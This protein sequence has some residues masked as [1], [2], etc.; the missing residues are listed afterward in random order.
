MAYTEAN[1][2]YYKKNPTH[3]TADLD[4]DLLLTLIDY[5]VENI[6][7]IKP[8]TAE[9]I[10][11]A[12]KLDPSVFKYIDFSKVSIQ[13]LE[14]VV[15]ENPIMIQHIYSPNSTLIKIA[16]TEDVNVLPYIEKYIDASIYEWLLSQNGLLLEFIP[17][18]KQTE[19]MTMIAI[20]QN[21]KAYQYAYIKTKATDIYLIHQ[22]STRIYEITDYWPELIIPIIEYNPRYISKF[23]NHPELLTEDIIKLALDGDSDIYKILP[24]PSFEIMK[25]SIDLDIDLF[26]YMPFNQQLIEY[27]LLTNGLALKYVKKKDLLTIKNAID[28]NVRALD[29]IPY[30]RQFLIDYA[31][32][33]NGIALK[34]IKNPT[35]AE[36]LSAIKREP[37]VIEYIPSEFITKEIQLYA[38]VGGVKNIPFIG[39]PYDEE[40]YLQILRMDPSYIFKISN[41]STKM[42][43]TA[44]EAEGIL[45]RFFPNW[46]TFFSTELIKSA[47]KQ[48]GSIF[49]HVTNK[50][51][52]LA[53]TAIENFP[54][55]LQWV[56]FQDLEL[57]NLAVGLDPRTLYFVDK[58]IMNSVLLN[59]ALSLDPNFFTRI[60]GELTWEQWIA[61]T[62]IKGKK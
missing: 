5:D 10:Y 31:F 14:R 35:Y 12:F 29:Y 19:N 32:E 11:E 20:Q 17:S 60:E 41:P 16:L 52:Y 8:Q 45:I 23:F 9:F 22:D 44:F 39:I 13:F 61:L 54:A 34:Y 36:C 7:Y 58:K 42:Y 27:A 55:A 50:S 38:L 26:I 62:G 57:A 48:D 33:L 30:P 47:L 4:N 21:I 3:I 18:Y 51:K 49:E 43:T 1:L 25:Y 53:T 2:N 15:K 28:K 37:Y 40:V 24:N 46:N 59:L 56:K 6:K